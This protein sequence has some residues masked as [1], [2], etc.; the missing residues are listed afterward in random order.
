MQIALVVDIGVARGE[1]VVADRTRLAGPLRARRRHPLVIRHARL[2]EGLAVDRPGRSMIV[3]LT[4]LRALIDMAEN[5]E[6]EFRVLV[7]DLPLRSVL[8]QIA[9]NEFRVGAR[10]LD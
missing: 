4:F 2:A 8:G 7:E 3:R 5:A 6:T 9:A 10:F 1:L